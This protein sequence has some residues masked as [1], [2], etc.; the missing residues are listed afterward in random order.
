MAVAREAIEAAGADVMTRPVGTG[1][2]RAQGMAQGLARRARG[3]SALPAHRVSRVGESRAPR[4]RRRDE[5]RRAAGDRP[6][7]DRDHRGVPARGPVV[8]EGRPRLRVDRRQHARPHAAGREAQ[9][10]ARRA[11]RAPPAAG[12]RPTSCSSTSTSTT[13]TLGGMAPERIALRRAI[14]MGFNTPSSSASCTRARRSRRTSSCRRTS[15]ATTPRW[16]QGDRVRSRRRARAA[17][18]LRLDATAT[19]TATAR[20]RTASRSCWCTA[21]CRTRGRAK[22]TR[23]G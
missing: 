4:A 15:R 20:R 3:E 22:P 5:G 14:G 2:Y 11:R 9:A 17:R 16:P 23:C 10:R 1:P 8:R 13:A 7:R 6:H 18:P 12:R 19:A 21:R